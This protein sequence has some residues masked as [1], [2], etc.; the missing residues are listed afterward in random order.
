M[1]GACDRR[2][3]GAGRE[4]LGERRRD[5]R[6]GRRVGER[7]DHDRARAARIHAPGRGH[8]KRR[9]RGRR[10]V[11]HR[12]RHARRAE[13]ARAGRL[14]RAA[15]SGRRPQPVASGR[16]RDHGR[17]ARAPLG[18]GVR[19][20][21]ALGA[22]TGRAGD[23]SPLRPPLSAPAL[24]RPAAAGHDRDGVRVRPAGRGARRADH[25]ARRPDPGPHPHRAHA[26]AGR[27]GDGDGL[28]LARPRRRGADGRPHRRHVR[29]PGRRE[30]AGR[31]GHLPAAAPVHPGA[32]R[33][34][35]R[36]PPPARAPGHPGRR[37]RR[38]RVA[39]GVRVR[40]PVRV[41][42]G[43]LPRRRARARGGRGAALGPVR[44]L[45]RARAGR[46][47]A[48][49]RAGRE[50]GGRRRRAPP[51]G[52]RPRGRVPVGPDAEP[53]RP[54]RVVRHR[55][56]DVRRARRRV[57]ERQ[58]HDR[59][60]HRRPA[61]ADRRADRLRRGGAARGRALAN[62]RPAPPDPDRLPEPV[63]VA[64]PAPPGR[65]LDRAAAAG[66]P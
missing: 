56:R 19:R 35:P 34:H 7:Q 59:P 44:P 14:V 31:R 50:P 43:A 51:R 24:G 23:R 55:G 29:R 66:A 57:R 64:Q 58:D 65:G 40:A 1:P 13:P 26:A 11:G 46:G 16:R 52:V 42:A 25:R 39:R 15:G 62:A 8:P 30:R 5:P 28:R 49:R 37:R 4:L 60:L 20:L 61:R 10:P 2:G 63:R 27:G 54:R 33:R 38:R 45:G 22:R 41:R 18:V 17:A 6:P 36:R 47:R 21:G 48:W 3:G 12:A 32:G 53:R 9:D